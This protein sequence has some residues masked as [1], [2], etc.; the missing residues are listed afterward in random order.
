MANDI[1]KAVSANP[2][3]NGTMLVGTSQTGNYITRDTY[4]NNTPTM[5]DI[6]AKYDNRFYNGIFVNVI[7]S[8]V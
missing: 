7:A 4:V 1:V 5:S 8:G 6:E 2:V 3:K